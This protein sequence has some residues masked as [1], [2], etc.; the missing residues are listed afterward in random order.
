MK[1]AKI[2]SFLLALAALTACSRQENGSSQ[3]SSSRSYSQRGKASVKK[4]SKQVEMI[5]YQTTYRGKAY[6][7][8]AEVYLPADYD[9]NQKHNV[10]YLVHGSTE[11]SGGRSTL[12]EDGNFVSLLNQ[13]DEG[14]QLKGTIVVFPTYY[15]SSSSVKSDYYADRPLNERFAR[16]EFVQDLMPAVESH[17]KTY[18]QNISR[19]ALEASRAHRAFGGFSMGAITSWYAFQYDLPYVSSFL[20]MAGDAWNVTSDGS[21]SRPEATAALLAKA[22]EKDGEDFKIL[23][24]VGTG[25]PTGGSME[26]QISA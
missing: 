3:A 7:K 10:I 6:T 13:L 9:K 2:I 26:P 17:Y 24:G 22:A 18:A 15:P 12:M 14:G 1:T 20:P 4:T 23:A 21:S 25:D 19:G 16:E 8:Q 5:S 11:V